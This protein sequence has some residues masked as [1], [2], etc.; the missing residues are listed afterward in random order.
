M[1]VGVLGMKQ[2]VQHGAEQESSRD[3]VVVRPLVMGEPHAL[4]LPH[5]YVKAT[6][7][8]QT[9][10]VL[11]VD[12]FLADHL[13]VVISVLNVVPLMLAIAVIPAKNL[14]ICNPM[15]RVKIWDFSGDVS[16]KPKG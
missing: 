9:P 5:R 10:G 11:V 8:S 6:W 12:L 1:A 2:L 3:R 13:V 15:Y 7:P 14:R 4:A 16:K